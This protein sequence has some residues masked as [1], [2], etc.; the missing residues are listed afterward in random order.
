MKNKKILPLSV[1]TA[2][3]A[4][5]FY[6]QNKYQELNRLCDQPFNEMSS[7]PSKI[8]DLSWLSDHNFQD[9]MTKQVR[10]YLENLRQSGQI[11]QGDQVLAYDYYPVDQAQATLV[12]IHGFNEFKEKYWEFIYY[13]LQANIEVFTYDQ[14][15]HGQSKISLDST[16]IDIDD[17]SQYLDDLDYFL[18]E[19]V[20]PQAKSD[21]LRIFGHSM[22]GAVVTAYLEE[23]SHDLGKAIINCPMLMINTGKLS[24]Y[25]SHLFAKLATRLGFKRAYIP[26]TE[27]HDPIESKVF[28]EYTVVYKPSNRARYFHDLDFDLHAYPTSGGSL[29]WLK[30]SIEANNRMTRPENLKKIDVPCLLIRAGQDQVVDPR[31][32]YTGQKYI[33][34][35]QNLVFDSAYHEISSDFDSVI[36]E[37]YS[38]LID[39]ILRD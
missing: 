32:I 26:T 35:V 8:M 27:K 17:F 18:E 22:G 14:R 15:G 16:Q 21:R 25:Q 34:N 5:L 36:Q 31:G 2:G 39:F 37:Y 10:P 9:Q 6:D 28:K 29:T 33:P 3:L 1:I 4:Y 13:C 12:I 11:F 23:R 30:T 38:H 19:I 24:I 20:Y 7:D